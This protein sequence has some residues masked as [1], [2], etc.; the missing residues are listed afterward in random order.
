MDKTN[1]YENSSIVSSRLFGLCDT[2]KQEA[3]FIDLDPNNK[4]KWDAEVNNSVDDNIW[5][6]PVDCNPL[7]VFTGEKCDCVLY[8]KNYAGIY[9]IELKKDRTG[10]SIEKGTRQLENTIQVFKYCHSLDVYRHAHAF[11]CN[12]KKP[13]FASGHMQQMQDFK[14]RTGVTLFLQYEIRIKM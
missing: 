13:A 6:V 10:G 4:E 5:F 1:F 9:F 3:V 8:S 14:S 2:R 12:K 11:V 7:I